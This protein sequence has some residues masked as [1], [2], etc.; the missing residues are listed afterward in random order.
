MLFSILIAASPGPIVTPYAQKS[1]LAIRAVRP[2]RTSVPCYVPLQVSVDLGATFD[3]PF[4][5][6]DVALDAEVHPSSGKPF[7]VPGFFDRPYVRK[8]NVLEPSGA[9]RWQIRLAALK[10][11][12]HRVVVRLKDR[13]GSVRKE[14][15]FTATPASDPGF[16]RVSPRDGRYFETSNGRSFYAIG[17]NLCWSGAGGMADF[18]RWIPALGKAKANFGRLWLGPDWVSLALERGGRPE[19]GKGMGQFDL[20]NAARLD[21]VLDL[22]DRNG[23]K[24][25]LCI[26]SFNILRDRDGYNYWEK[27]PHNAANGGP[28]RSM[29][30]FWTDPAMA[31]FYRDKLRYLVARY[32]AKKSVFA[33]EFWN[34]VDVIR[35]IPPIP[36]RKWHIEMA[37]VLK[38]LDP[39]DHP[40]TTSLGM[41]EGD[42]R[43]DL[44]PGIDY[45]QTHHYSSPD[46]AG[47]AA[48][49]QLRKAAW[50]KPHMVA[51]IAADVSG[52]A[53]ADKDKEGHQ[54]HDPI[55]ATVATGSAGSAQPWFWDSLIDPNNLYSLF[56]SVA[57]FVKGVDYPGER[58]KSVQPTF[59]YQ[60]APRRTSQD[61]P[62]LGSTAV[63]AS[64]PSNRPQTR[65]IRGAAMIGGPV[66]EMQHGVVNHP[67]WHN[68]ISFQVDLK[69]SSTLEVEVNRVSAHG[70]AALQVEIDGKPVLKK[71]F[72]DDDPTQ[73][74]ELSLYNGTYR[75]QIPAGRHVVKVENVGADWFGASYRFVG[76]SS[77]HLPLVDAWVIAGR[78]TALGWVRATGRTWP[79][80][81]VYK[82]A[83]ERIEPTKMRLTGLKP[84][85]YQVTLWNTWK[86]A[87][88]QRFKVKTT[89]K[90][91][92]EVPL[93]AI[94]RDL[95]FKLVRAK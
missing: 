25:L 88:T 71:D 3:N 32:G 8:G 44:A 15:T 60:G 29:S 72:P 78:T 22:A 39:Y 21:D 36:V 2:A 7:S 51:E 12:K 31:K 67:D 20:E 28:L 34:E 47:V 41:T 61:L 94:H 73:G 1:T 83:P 35:D 45:V 74:G 66:S 93:H 62:I 90:G 69:T 84:G 82:N 77:T 14:F 42:P 70:G 9:H 40:T 91:A 37:K 26:D 50:G 57:D 59:T 76:V 16:V 54:A 87:P 81:V 6:D 92:A 33:W 58:F 55:W 68:P 53:H 27:T 46:L 89:A 95:A 85:V 19:D 11:G 75:V 79:R 64:H 4:D 13:S 65:T 52:D 86:G 56:T 80:V 48:T 5:P 10:P 17:E 43:I 38:G 23:V 24:M 30:D 18:E 49:Q 63:W